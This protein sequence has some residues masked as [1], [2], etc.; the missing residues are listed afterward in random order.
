MD[1]KNLLA[2]QF[3]IKRRQANTVDALIHLAALTFVCVLSYELFQTAKEPGKLHYTMIS[4]ACMFSSVFI[5]FSA[6]YFLFNEKNCKHTF[7]LPYL[8]GKY[9]HM[10][11]KRLLKLELFALKGGFSNEEFRNFIREALPYPLGEVR[12]YHLNNYFADYLSEKD[13]KSAKKKE[14]EQ[15]AERE[16]ELKKTLGIS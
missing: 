4:A 6:V 10:P 11:A 16:K 8:F 15:I 7:C 3:R 1:I 2:E 13:R 9:R 5:C 14:A 12:N